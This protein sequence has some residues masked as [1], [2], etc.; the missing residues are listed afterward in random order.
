MWT[1][2][3]FILYMVQWTENSSGVKGLNKIKI[4][5]MDLIILF[6]SK[7]G[8]PVPICY[9]IVQAV[10][11]GFIQNI[12][13]KRKFSYAGKFIIALFLSLNVHKY[14]ASD[15]KNTAIS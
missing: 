4:F 2:H 9:Y 3:D 6:I 14:S 7:V 13:L 8:L 11:L 10:F 12:K 15:T 5:F 1:V